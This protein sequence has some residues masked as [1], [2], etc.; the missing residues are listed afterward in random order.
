MFDTRHSSQIK[1]DNILRWQTELAWYQYVIQFRPGRDNLPADAL[2]RVSAAV[3]VST[4]S[5]QDIH[6]S[7]C[8]PGITRLSHYVKVKNQA[9]S[10]DKIKK[11]CLQYP[12]CC[13]FKPRYFCPPEPHLIR[14]LRPFERLSVDF[15][16]PKPFLSRNKYLLVIVDEYS[17]FPSV[18]SCSDIN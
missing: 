14:V 1:N 16:G 4:V 3:S 15:I 11:V 17:R 2:S 10:L 9:F 5:L 7:L 13:E 12:V 8:H 6:E 18:Y